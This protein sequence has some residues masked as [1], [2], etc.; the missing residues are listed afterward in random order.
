MQPNTKMPKGTILHVTQPGDGGVARV[1]SGLSKWQDGEGHRVYVAGPPG[2]QLQTELSPTVALLPW[3]A[4]RSPARGLF[5]ETLALR[6]IIAQTNPDIVHLHSAKAG[7]IGRLAIRG[8]I[9]TVFQPHAW[10]FSATR[11]IV[12]R[13]TIAWERHAAR[14][15]SDIICLSSEELRL[16]RTVSEN[17]RTVIPNGVD[18][19]H[20]SPRAKLGARQRLSLPPEAEVVLCVG[21][22]TE[23]K[24]QLEFARSW[25]TL[26]KH[27]PNLVLALV[28]SGPLEEA[29]RAAY[30]GWQVIYDTDCSDTRDWIAA[31]DVVVAPSLWEGAALVPLEAMAMDRPV[32]G[33]DVGGLAAV[34]GRPELVP[35]P[36]DEKKL[37]EAV[38]LALL[39]DEPSRTQLSSRIRAHFGSHTS[40][41]SLTEAALLAS[42]SHK[43]Q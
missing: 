37:V 40:Y 2:T 7:L 19:E 31:S 21:R 35:P 13:M 9:A 28:G 10:S 17:V 29:I 34:V 33:Y 25:R 12:R 20:W 8:G 4:N 36:G 39:M 16:A 27:R 14:W 30:S 43:G 24:G 26:L 15:T 6:R 32:V 18:V 38:L 42:Q 11:G 22:L 23:Q 1:V 3:K 5:R 41:R